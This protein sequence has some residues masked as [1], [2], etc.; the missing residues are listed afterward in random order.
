MISQK[1]LCIDTLMKTILLCQQ[2]V[3]NFEIYLF[4]GICKNPHSA[5]VELNT[6]HSHNWVWIYTS[7][8]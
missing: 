1:R 6:G 3:N 2:K 4:G 7:I 8:L 5:S